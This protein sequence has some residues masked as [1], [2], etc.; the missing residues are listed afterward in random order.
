MLSERP[1]VRKDWVTKYTPRFRSVFKTFYDGF[2]FFSPVKIIGCTWKDQMRLQNRWNGKS[3]RFFDRIAPA[4]EN[5][6]INSRIV[7][8]SIKV[9]NNFW[10]DFELWVNRIIWDYTFPITVLN[11]VRWLKRIFSKLFS[12]LVAPARWIFRIIDFHDATWKRAYSF[13][14]CLFFPFNW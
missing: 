8:V 14:N 6:L 10:D 9:G 1:P 11:K 7:K 2:Q 13:L 4:L 12:R 5:V 3:F